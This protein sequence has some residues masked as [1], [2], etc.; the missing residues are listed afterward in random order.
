M[1][2]LVVARYTASKRTQYLA[3]FVEFASSWGPFGLEISRRPSEHPRCLS[4]QEA[5]CLSDTGFLLRFG[6]GLQEERMHAQE[7]SVR[8]HVPTARFESEAV[9][10]G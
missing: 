4:S 7:L 10:A 1:A 6:D 8:I 5:V 9:R 2:A 3:V